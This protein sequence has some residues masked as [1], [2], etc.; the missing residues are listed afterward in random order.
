MGES[1]DFLDS[2]GLQIELVN[3]AMVL[4]GQEPSRMDDRVL[5][6]IDQIRDGVSQDLNGPFDTTQVALIVHSE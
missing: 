2:L 1:S 3:S 5:I 4:E 6:E